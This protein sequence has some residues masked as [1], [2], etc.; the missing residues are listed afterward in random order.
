MIVVG[1]D[2]VD[3]K[4]NLFEL[5]V[6]DYISESRNPTEFL[7]RIASRIRKWNLDS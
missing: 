6:D 3:T 7:V 2:D 4:V 5:D 1:P